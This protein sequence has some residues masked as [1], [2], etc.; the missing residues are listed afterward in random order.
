MKRILMA[1]ILCAMHASAFAQGSQVVRLIVAFPAGGPADLVARVVSDK[2][3]AELGSSV[4]VDNRP[5]ASGAIAA[6]YVAKA[7]SSGNVLFLSNTGALAINPAI[8]KNLPYDPLKDFTPVSL[9]V[10][11]PTVLVTGTPTDLSNAR[12]L[13]AKMKSAPAP[14]SAGS[15]GPGSASHFSIEMFQEATGLTLLHIPFKGAAPALADV[16][17]R[18]VDLFFGDLPGVNSFIQAGRLKALGIA[19]TRRSSL[20]PNVQTLEEQG[21]RGVAASGWWGIVVPAATPAERVEILNRSLGRVLRLPEVRQQFENMGAAAAP[22]TPKEFG[23]LLTQ[24]RQRWAGLA[25][26]RSI[27]AN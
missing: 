4:I 7:G 23:D 11:T 3:A 17:G 27:T 10:D 16:V 20:L 15:S 14:L 26:R 19:G 5:G 6:S 22:S 2:L 18:R 8:E 24:D 9:V 1:A 13:L 25:Q 12:D 21:I